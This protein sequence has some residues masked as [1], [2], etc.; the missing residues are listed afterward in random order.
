M[1]L[2]GKNAI[3]IDFKTGLE[4]YID[5]KQVLEYRKL[6]NEMGYLNVDVY[7]LYIGLNKVVQI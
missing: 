6:L 3:I 4:K 7:L 2:H 5:K 1:L